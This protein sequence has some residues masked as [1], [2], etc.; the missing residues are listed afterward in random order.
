MSDL[1]LF[2]DRQLTKAINQIDFGRVQLE[3]KNTRV[4]YLRNN[5]NDWPIS[6]IKLNAI[7]PDDLKITYPQ[8]LAA[9]ENSQV[10][11]EWNPS[12]LRREPLN[13]NGLFSGEKLIG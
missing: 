1:Q 11:I 10:I 5:D 2:E 7:L 3:S 8:Y 12:K 9:S 4:L 13:L 6:D